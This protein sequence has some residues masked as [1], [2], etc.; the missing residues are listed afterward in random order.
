MPD[1]RRVDPELVQ[2]VERGVRGV[3]HGVKEQRERHVEGPRGERLQRALA[4]RRRQ[5]VVFTAVMHGVRRP[6]EVVRVWRGGG[7][8]ARQETA[9]DETTSTRTRGASGLPR[10]ARADERRTHVQCDET[11]SIRSRNQAP[12]P[13]TRANLPHLVLQMPLATSLLKT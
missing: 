5:V 3:E 7:S 8:V 2:R 1:Q 9:A 10:D 12:A 11:S 6:H 13:P 4:Q